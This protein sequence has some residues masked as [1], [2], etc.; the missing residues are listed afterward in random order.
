MRFKSL[1]YKASY[2]KQN[3][4][5][6]PEVHGRIEVLKEPLLFTYGT[7]VTLNYIYERIDLYIC[8]YLKIK[9]RD[10]PQNGSCPHSYLQEYAYDL[11]DILKEDHDRAGRVAQCKNKDECAQT[12]VKDLYRING[13]IEFVYCCYDEHDHNKERMYERCCYDLDYRKYAYLENDF[14]NKI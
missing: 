9:R 3:N 12:V 5:E 2:A 10:I 8:L 1:E 6:D 13:R 14:F 4:R 11:G 7:P